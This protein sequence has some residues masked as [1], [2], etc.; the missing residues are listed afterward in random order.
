MHAR[1]L[2]KQDT[3]FIAGP[4]AP[5]PPHISGCPVALPPTYLSLLLSLALSDV[6]NAMVLK[7]KRFVVLH[8]LVQIWFLLLL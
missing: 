5:I 1:R 6:P 2:L 3:S 7:K 4:P 8:H